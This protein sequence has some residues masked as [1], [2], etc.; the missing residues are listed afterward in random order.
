[1]TRGARSISLYAQIG[2]TYLKWA[3]SL[4][5]LAVIVFIPVC[6]L[7]SIALQAD[8]GSLD[9]DG[10][11]QIFAAV[12]ALAV[13]AITG[14]LGEVF[15]TG[16]VAISLTH[17]HG[18]KPPPL[19]EIARMVNYRRL[20]AVDLIYGSIVAIGI[21]LLFAPGVAAFVWLS[22]AAPVVEIEGKGVRGSFARSARL[23]RGRFWTVFAVLVPLEL[24]GEAVTG[25]AT[26]LAH[27][28]LGDTLVSEWLAGTLSNVA[29]TPFY[30]V[31]A[32]LLTVRLI[33]EK[34]GDVA[35]LH[36]EP[37]R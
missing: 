10:G 30:A 29:F 36:P 15:Y 28:L 2:R 22:L 24:A 33:R 13:L 21:V 31:A 12:A 3:R 17:P 8:I 19:R 23:V 27:D 14:L 11:L 18:G 16:A 25:L 6:F 20:I 26:L 1:M 9:F 32:V 4:L 5:P 34:D 35:Q 7:H 37:V